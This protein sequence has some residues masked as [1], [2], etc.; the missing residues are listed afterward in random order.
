MVVSAIQTPIFSLLTLKLILPSLFQFD[1]SSVLAFSLIYYV[2]RVVFKVIEIHVIYCKFCVD[3]VLS[4]RYCSNEVLNMFQY[5]P[6]C[7]SIRR[8][9]HLDHHPHLV[10]RVS[11]LSWIQAHETHATR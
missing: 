6:D 4:P 3:S 1:N 7:W 11:M 2:V 9:S 10:F 5:P 8:G